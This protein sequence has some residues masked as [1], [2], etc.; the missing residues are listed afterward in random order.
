MGHHH[1]RSAPRCCLARLLLLTMCDITHSPL[2]IAV[3]VALHFTKLSKSASNSSSGVG[4]DGLNRNVPNMSFFPSMI[5]KDTPQSAYTSKSI[6]D[7]TDYV[8]VF[9]DEFNVP[10]RSFYPGD[11]PFWEGGDLHYWQTGD[12]E[13]YEP[14]QLT[15]VNG[16]LEITLEKFAD[17]S[18]NYNLSY[19]SGMMSTWNK[20]C[21]TSKMVISCTDAH[22]S[23]ALPAAASRQA[24]CFPARTTS[25]AFG[26]LS[27]PW[28]T[29]VAS[30]TV[31]HSRAS[32]VF[33]FS[34]VLLELIVFS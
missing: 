17:I 16:S 32:Y 34:T 25:S 33:P 19:R 7:S 3:P 6:Q 29:S 5:D 31:H 23:S 14:G 28:A 26:R 20:V 15:T 24:S 8:L 18:Q 12:L 27:G 30:A 11:D 9:S 10:G 1:P 22:H 13:W 21:I 4:A 2:S